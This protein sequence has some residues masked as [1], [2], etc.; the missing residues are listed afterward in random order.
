[1]IRIRSTSWHLRFSPF[2]CSPKVCSRPLSSLS[3]FRWD[4]C[5]GTN[6]PP[7]AAPTNDYHTIGNV[8]CNPIIDNL[9][10]LDKKITDYFTK[11]KYRGLS[12][13]P[14]GPASHTL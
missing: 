12:I 4:D 5:V 13:W 10:N 8:Q 3:H 7:S 14:R 1:M 2:K 11:E 9:G 6:I